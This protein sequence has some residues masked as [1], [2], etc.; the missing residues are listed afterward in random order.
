MTKGSR[1]ISIRMSNRKI[2]ELEETLKDTTSLAETS[3][4][5]TD[6]KKSLNRAMTRHDEEASRTKTQMDE[7]QKHF[8]NAGKNV[9]CFFSH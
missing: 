7:L 4:E 9:L 6:L 5:V 2:L 8:D 1:S 3:T